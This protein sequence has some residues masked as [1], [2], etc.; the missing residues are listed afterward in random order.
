MGGDATGW[1]LAALALA[2]L[3][4][5]ALQLQERALLPGAT[6]AG[7][8]LAG[9][10]GVALG[11]ALGRAWGRGRGGVLLLAG[12]AALGFAAAGGRAALRLAEQLPAALEGQ[13]IVVVGVVA[14]LPQRSDSGLRFRFA[15]EQAHRHGE[16][17]ALPPLLALG[18]TSGYHEDA[19][20]TAPQTELRAGQ[21]WRFDVRL[22]RPHGNLNPHGFDHE[23]WLF[24][25]G[26]RATGY[27]RDVNAPARLGDASGHRVER[28]RQRLRD[29]IDARVA[30]RRAA[31]VL[32]A[33]AVGDQGA[34]ERDDW[35]LFRTTGVAH[36][37][38]ISGLHVTMFAWLAGALIGWAWRRSDRAMLWLAAPSAARWGGLAAACAYAVFCGWGVPAQ[39]TVWML[40]LVTGLTALGVHWPW[41]LVLLSAAVLV[42]AFDPWALL[43]PGFWLSFA[44]V[45]LLMASGPAQPDAPAAPA[46]AGWRGVPARLATLL[47]GG[48]RTQVVATLG[49]TPLTLVFFQQVSLVGFAANLVA[50]PLVTL[51]ITPLALLGVLAAP[52]WQLGAWVL[53]GL[54]WLLERLASLPW[55]VWTVPAAPAWAQ[56]AA[57][58]GA[59]LLVMPLAWRWRLVAV[60]LCLP[61]LMPPVARPPAGTFELLAVDVGQ[62]TAVLVRTRAHLLVY[63]AGPQYGRDSDAGQ[64][65]LLPLLRARGEHRIDTLVLSHRDNDHVGGASSLLRELPVGELL[66][67]LEDGHALLRRAAPARRCA[68][69]QRWTWDGVDF[70]VLQP[71]ASAYPAGTRSN[72]VSCV[73][74]VS[75]GA[76]AVLLTGDIERDQEAQLVA[77]QPAA[78]R[79][80]VLIVPHHGSR[81][82]SSSAFLAAAQPRTAVVQAGY[83]NRYGHPAPEVLERYRAHGIRL[84]TSAG[85]GAWRW[86]SD[87]PDGGVCERDAARRYWH[88]PAA[89]GDD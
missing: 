59:A 25:Q 61:L 33:L 51:L 12:V 79:S 40:A 31:G 30:D 21:R 63:D 41:A 23:L 35:D 29:A 47:R 5:V 86:T 53:Q 58:V 77:A 16:P 26:I 57:L 83:R 74:R 48:V 13:D 11:V 8:A 89:R 42:T 67:S 6:Y 37:M 17:V 7:I 62:G 9:A 87:D 10:V 18:W 4:G 20:L 43:Q 71:P 82:S 81:T 22:R 34:I 52:L 60:P 36:L 75:A 66:S 56:A 84:L 39:R 46:T 15:V 45:G 76:Q 38:S 28:L 69:G 19:V 73:V 24:E 14:S 50:I 64:R 55:A 72:A 70:E 54:V 85:C 88:H 32:A 49:L 3:A 68:A 78:L 80:D 1:R 27:V 44:A 65:V 2:W